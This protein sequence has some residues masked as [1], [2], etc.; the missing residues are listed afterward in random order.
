MYTAFRL[1]FGFWGPGFGVGFWVWVW[2]GWVYVW[3]RGLHCALFDTHIS[4]TVCACSI[5]LIGSCIW[6]RGRNADE[7]KG[8]LTLLIYWLVPFSRSVTIWPFSHLSLIIVWYARDNGKM[9]SNIE[10]LTS[11]SIN[12]TFEAA[13]EKH[14]LNKFS[15][16]LYPS[17]KSRTWSEQFRV[18]ALEMQVVIYYYI[19][20]VLEELIACMKILAN[21]KTNNSD[22]DTKE[23]CT[24]TSLN[25]G[26]SLYGI[27]CDSPIMH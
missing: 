9:K 5:K 16:L 7:E 19:V 12:C 13:Y 26:W 21:V 22:I 27:F 4:S 24:C 10:D 15:V 2:F 17:L 1:E 11:N 25:I 14:L 23:T 8:T 18:C 6:C 3:S 20:P